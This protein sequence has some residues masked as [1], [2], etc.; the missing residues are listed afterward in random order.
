MAGMNGFTDLAD[1]VR[2]RERRAV[3][4]ALSLVET[5]GPDAQS[6]L[7]LLHPDTGRGHIV[8]VTGAP[9]TG[10]STLV[11]AITAEYRRRG[12]TVGVIAVDPTSPFT[13]GAILGD[14]IRMQSHH[15]DQGVFIRSMASRGQLG[16]LAVATSDA[17][18]VLDAAGFDPILVETV[19]AG[20]SE[21]EIAGAAHT[22]IV[23]LVPNLGDDIQAIKAGILEIAD[24][25]DVNKADLPGADQAVATLRAMM[26]LGARE[27]AQKDR[28]AASP[29]WQIPIQETVGATGKGIGGLVDRIQEHRAY[30]ESSGLLGDLERDRA[31]GQ[32]RDI[33]RT[34]L[35]QE[36]LTN[37][38][39]NGLADTAA[40][41]AE[42]TID[43]YTA[44]EEL[45]GWRRLD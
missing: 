3:A 35:L 31:E 32:L 38:P 36:L 19:G 13:G 29:P 39:Q 33:L 18:R 40:R 34:W 12:H 21:V 28:A 8:G 17:V 26:M 45:L 15:G 2:R 7:A 6:L 14:R 24:I 5:G 30:L 41:V 10:K 42:R 25:F 37:L 16:G 43:P 11:N 9:G 44:A 20:Q 22:T 23:V 27:R 1:R 4:R